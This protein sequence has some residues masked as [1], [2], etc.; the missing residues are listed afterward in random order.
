MSEKEIIEVFQ[1]VRDNYAGKNKTKRNEWYVHTAALMD[2]I[3]KDDRAKNI[4]RKVKIVRSFCNNQGVVSLQLSENNIPY[5]KHVLKEYKKKV[6][7][8]YDI[9]MEE[10]YISEETVLSDFK[11]YLIGKQTSDI[12]GVIHWMKGTVELVGFI[13]CIC[14]ENYKVEWSAVSEIFYNDSKGETF[15]PDSLKTSKSREPKKQID[16]FKRLI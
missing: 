14:D 3:L 7:A 8:M 5:L 9:L 2:G 6:E 1:T 16:I 13:S 12:K 15:K 4:G 11:Y 10:G